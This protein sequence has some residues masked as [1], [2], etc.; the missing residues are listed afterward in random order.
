MVCKKLLPAQNMIVVSAAGDDVTAIISL[1]RANQAEASL[2]QRS[3]AEVRQYL[4]DFLLLKDARGQVLGCIAVHQHSATIAEVF[5][6]AVLP[7]AQG[8]GLGKHLME[9]CIE[10]ARSQGIE[11]LWLAT[12]KSGYFEKFGFRSISFWQLPISIL[13]TKLKQ[14]F[15][16]PPQVW[17][18]GL[19][20]R[21][22]VMQLSLK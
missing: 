21:Q 19:L 2:L 6:L 20:A 4:D 22:T 12:H 5:S 15:Q 11:Q 17:V 3:E 1:F 18:T 14:L 9:T 7:D 8:R 16:R 10:R 13:V